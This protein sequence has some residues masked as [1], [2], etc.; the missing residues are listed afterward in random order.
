MPADH[1]D[2]TVWPHDCEAIYRSIAADDRRLADCLLVMVRQTWPP[3][4]TSGFQK[5]PGDT[6][7]GDHS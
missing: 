1:S 7:Q 6:P 3:L 5:A 4:D 2:F